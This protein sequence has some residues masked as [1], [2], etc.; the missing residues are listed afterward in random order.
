[1]PTSFGAWA[2]SATAAREGRAV[3][4]ARA[5]DDDYAAGSAPGAAAAAAAAGCVA[6]APG[7]AALGRAHLGE[8]VARRDDPGSGRGVRGVAAARAGRR[9]ERRLVIA[10]WRP[11][12]AGADG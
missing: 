8:N 1:M 10:A 12:D 4:S 11:R 5:G 3:R 9:R 6:R 2:T 7:G